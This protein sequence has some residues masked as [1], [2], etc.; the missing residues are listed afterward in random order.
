M[1]FANTAAITAKAT[2]AS[3]D[4]P[5]G[6]NAAR[7]SCSPCPVAASTTTPSAATKIRKSGL[8]S[9]AIVNGVSCRNATPRTAS[10]SAPAAATTYGSTCRVGA[11]HQPEQDH[12]EQDQRG[13]RC[14]DVAAARPRGRSG[15]C[16][17]RSSLRKNSRNAPY[18]TAIQTSH[19]ASINAPN[20]RNESPDAW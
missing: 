19:G 9:S 10:T 1:R 4:V 8:V 5:V 18:S 2:N 17:V 14:L 13:S 11:T 15:S 3:R 6:S 20:P 16:A 7:P 12:G